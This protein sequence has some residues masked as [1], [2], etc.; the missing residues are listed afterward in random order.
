MT[1][2]MIVVAALVVGMLG[3]FASAT[4][5]TCFYERET[6][7]GLNK[8]CYYSCPSG[9]YAITIRSA[10]LCPMTVKKAR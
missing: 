1:K 8:I 7:E 3:G 9:A 10:S 5:E 2:K 6:V 4:S